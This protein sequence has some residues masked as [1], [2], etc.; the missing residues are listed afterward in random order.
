MRIN[1]RLR[2]FLT[3]LPLL[4]IIAVLGTAGAVLLYRLSSS[5]DAILRE[6]YRSVIYMQDLN[7]TL[8]RIDAGFQ[9]ALAEQDEKARPQ[10]DKAKNEL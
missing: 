4:V 7:E 6:N 10:D 9:L 8:D 2:I 5:I 3:L 1:L